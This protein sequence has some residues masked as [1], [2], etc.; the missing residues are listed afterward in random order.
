MKFLIKL[1]NF[2]LY[3]IDST[4]KKRYYLLFAYRCIQHRNRRNFKVN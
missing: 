1:N 3:C 4:R 2:A